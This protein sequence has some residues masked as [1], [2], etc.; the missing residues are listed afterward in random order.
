MKIKNCILII[1]FLFVSTSSAFALPPDP[2]NAALLYYQ[3]FLIYERPDDT[4]K[5]LIADLAY[6]EIQPDARTT[7]FIESQNAVIS[8]AVHAAELPDCHWGI[9]YSDG[10]DCQMS[11]LSQAKA[12]THLIMAD[13]R[14]LAANGDYQLALERCLTARKMALHVGIEP[15]LIS[16][17]VEIAIERI[18]NQC[19]QDILSETNLDLDT[20]KYLKDQIDTLT[21]KNLPIEYYYE[22][23]RQVVAMYMTTEKIQEILTLLE[24]EDEEQEDEEQSEDDTDRRIKNLIRSADEQFCQRSLE[25]FNEYY[26]NVFC[27]LELSYQQAY[28]QLKSLAE[29][30]AED[31][32]ENEN[33]YAAMTT[34]LAPAL[35]RCYNLDVRGR[36]HTNALKTALEIYI[37]NAQ[38]GKLPDTLSDDWPKD[39]FSGESFAYEITNDGFIL[40]CK[41]KDL[42]KDVTHE[43]EFK[44]VE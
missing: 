10:F 26:T 4:M 14:T 7:V 39:L 20:L 8:L 1:L 43:Y 35:N 33:L 2:D 22:A 24:W 17:L 21:N 42:D 29:K 32:K 40:R 34:T 18:S 38:T 37:S 19:I 23:E 3:V 15:T 11:H 13:A 5:D 36:T 9:K 12:L 28:S 25:Y 31:F 27:A 30:L 44:V 6:G 16:F 41:A